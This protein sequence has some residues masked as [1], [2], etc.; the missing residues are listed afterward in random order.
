MRALPRGF[1]N[2]NFF[3]G[4]RPTHAAS[5]CAQGSALE[6]LFRAHQGFTDMT[7]AYRSLSWR[8][9]VDRA[10]AIRP[11]ATNDLATLSFS[12]EDIAEADRVAR[13]RDH[14]LSLAQIEPAQDHPFEAREVSRTLPAL[15]LMSLTLSAARIIRKRVIQGND[16]VALFVN[17]TGRAMVSARGREARLAPGDG[18]L[19]SCNDAMVCDRLS[20]GESLS[21]RVPRSVLSSVVVGL[22]DVIMRPIPRQSETLK[23]LTYYAGTLIDGN[24]LAASFLRNVAVNH[25]HDLIALS[26]G[27][28]HNAAEAANA[29]GLRAARLR[30]AKA[31][32]VE[33][34]SRRDLSVGVVAAHLG[35]TPRY[36]QRLFEA[37][38]TT[39]SAFLLN[40]RLARAY[41]MLCD[42]QF[43]GRP[44]GLIAY[45]VGFG[46]LSYF[47]RCF[48]RQ[49]GVTPTDIKEANAR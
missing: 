25:L 2:D 31:Y 30:A 9:G 14:H 22:D 32:I 44:V 29:Q 27:A 3:I 1:S 5:F 43:Y 48:R 8:P 49:Y 21:I 18:V 7:A 37:E 23:L 19:I 26:L 16:E 15:H 34:S 39:F 10:K 6:H 36:L 40:Q 13:W 41:R 4:G 45:D 24:A 47:N 11:G 12:T 38:G 33:S 20:Y 46:D 28:T 42:L 17:R 35:V